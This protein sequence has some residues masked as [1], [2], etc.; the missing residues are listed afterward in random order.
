MNSILIEY[1]LGLYF[2]GIGL[3]CLTARPFYRSAAFLQ[4]LFGIVLVLMAVAGF[5]FI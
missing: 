5:S 2:I 3:T 4:F 1:L